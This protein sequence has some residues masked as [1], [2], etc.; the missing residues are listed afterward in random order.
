MADVEAAPGQPPVNGFSSNGPCRVRASRRNAARDWGPLLAVAIAGMLLPLVPSPAAAAS[1]AH[2]GFQRVRYLRHSFEVPAGWRVIRLSPHVPTC[3][4]FDRH[5][6]YLGAPPPNQECPSSIVGTTE[7]MLIEP[8]PRRSARVAIE[9]PVT[10]RITVNAQQVHVTAT[11]DTH[12]GEI[13]R[14]LASASLPRPVMDPPKAQ[15]A[16]AD[17]P[18]PAR[19]TNY[20]GLGFDTCAAPSEAAMHAWWVHSPYSAI[21]IY[22]GGSDMACAQPNLTRSWLTH[23]AA[24][25]WHFIPMY[26][27]PQAALHE[28]RKSPAAQAIAAASD[29]ARR[30]RRLG[31][32]PGTPIYYD[33]EAYRRQSTRVLQFLSA[34][35]ARLHVLGYSSGVYGSSLSG[36]VDLARHYGHG[37]YAMPD[38]IDDALWNGRAS[39]YDSVLHARQWGHH[40]RVHQY[41]G[42]VTRTYGGT[43]IDIDQDYL[44]VRLPRKAPSGPVT[45]AYPA[46]ASATRYTGQA[47]V[48]CSA[49]SLAVMAAWQRSPYRAIGVYIGGVNR[50]C[51]QRRLTARWV[52]AVSERQWRLLPVY[53]GL[54]PSCLTGNAR[55]RPL[56][57]GARQINPAMA[58]RE[59]T[60]AADD[61][62]AR[63]Q[64]LGMRPGS[65]LYD[66]IGNYSTANVACGDAVLGFVSAWT[67]ELHRHG[68][69]AGISTYLGSGAR[70][71]SG[72]Y[73]STSF[74]RPDAVWAVSWDGKPSL[75]GWAGVPDSQWAI[76]QRA[77]GYRAPHSETHGGVAIRVSSDNVDAPVA[78]VTYDEKVTIWDGLN[79]R[80]GPSTS[81]PVAK[82]YA[83]DATVPVVC[84]ASGSA[85]I[86]SKVWDKL[87]NGTY[88]ADFYVSTPSL[89]G[90]SAPLPRCVY[91]YQVTSPAGERLRS[92]PATS[93]RV[94][95]QLPDGALAGV[96][97]QQR[98]PAAGST[99]VWDRLE[100]GQS[101]P[102]SSLATPGGN[103]HSGPAPGC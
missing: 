18:L 67:T 17:A 91:P 26:V 45:V 29:A 28:L 69:L 33:M 19:V 68:F 42:N 59:G 8:A 32:G 52:T 11:F 87:A 23:E 58:T 55:Q 60:A 40:R 61:A 13:R 15:S 96:V 90:Y 24:Q 94:V 4:R 6:V 30:A 71:L 25:G 72:L 92:G 39:T 14:I 93:Y 53:V 5:A 88:I 56:R 22:L 49:P 86:S 46:G 75:T 79:A 48:A 9:N 63:A 97:C 74:G 81:Y 64:A 21:G 43:T 66:Y 73:A 41:R 57:R 2:R 3:V 85:V 77:K 1:V 101:V 99:A 47:F 95:G 37:R 82:T 83:N 44:D 70:G 102:S 7:A 89:T 34:W 103:G 36:I 50:R 54:Q 51:G 35:T 98:G 100:G 80:T 84:Q 16:A 38:V 10:R 31:F 12:P 65:A 76:H 20:H 27:G 62:I 78:T